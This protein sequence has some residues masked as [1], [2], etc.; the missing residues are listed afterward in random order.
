MTTRP[1]AMR[2]RARLG[3]MLAGWGTVGLCYSTGQLAPGPAH[4]LRESAL[5]R[6]VPFDPS[7]VWFYLSFFALVPFA[8]LCAPPSRLKALMYAMQLCA[9]V[10]LLVFILW[11]TTLA[12]PP[13]PPGT[14]SSAALRVLTSSDSTQNCLPSLHGALTTLC[15]IASWSRAR[16][17]RGIFALSWGCAITW[18]VLQTRRHLA[19]DLGAGIGLGLACA[20]LVARLT[21]PLRTAVPAYRTTVADPSHPARI[22]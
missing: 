8:Y 22:N 4:V 15:V 14:A 11:P 5:D 3:M 10:S 2:L 16:L 19:I 7:A 18:S 20:W 6:L 1:T 13:I 21:R 9:I 12:Y 17:W